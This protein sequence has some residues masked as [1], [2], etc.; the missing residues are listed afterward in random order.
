MKR[1]I[2]LRS[3]L[4]EQ[5]FT[6]DL[7]LKHFYAAKEAAWSYAN[8][9]R[10]TDRRM[11]APDVTRLLTAFLDYPASPEETS[12]IRELIERDVRIAANNEAPNGAPVDKL[13]HVDAKGFEL[14]EIN[15]FIDLP[16]LKR[17]YK[18]AARKHHPD[19]GGNVTDMQALNRAYSA[20]F[21]IVNNEAYSLGGGTSPALP[22]SLTDWLFAMHLTLA[23]IHGDSYAADHG[24]FHIRTAHE[25][26][27]R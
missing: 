21:E 13:R 5:D 7:S 17:L 2:G 19:L 8:T 9:Y 1:L 24:V 26:M 22:S 11:L 27:R 3:I 14:L 16:T 18:R 12:F 6:E 25:F 4:W 23:C 20:F 15:D 10:I